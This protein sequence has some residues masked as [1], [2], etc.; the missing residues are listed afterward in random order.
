[1]STIDFSKCTDQQNNALIELGYL[2]VDSTKPFPRSLGNVVEKGSNLEKHLKEAFGE[3]YK[4]IEIIGYQNENGKGGFCGIA[5][6][7]QNGNTGI[8]FRGTE[9]LDHLFTKNQEDMIDNL[10]TGILGTS[11]QAVQAQ[12]FFKK[13]SDDSENNYLYG[14]S[15]GGELAM[16]AYVKNYQKIK[17]A[18]IYNPQPINP[19]QLSPVELL[20][21]RNKE[22]VDVIVNEGDMVSFI[23][24]VPYDY[25][26]VKNNEKNDSFFGPHMLDSVEYDNT[27]MYKE[28][29]A[30]NKKYFGQNTLAV[31]ACIITSSIQVGLKLNKTIKISD[32]MDVYEKIRK[33]HKFAEEELKNIVAKVKEGYEKLKNHIVDFNNNLKNMVTNFIESVNQFIKEHFNPGYKQSISNPHVIL[34]TYKLNDYAIRLNSVNSRIVKLDKSLDSLYLKVGWLSLYNLLKIFEADLSTGYNLKIKTCSWYLTETAKDFNNIE[35]IIV[36]NI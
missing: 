15:K 3:D 35:K 1:M 7:D 36:E 28:G 24:Q 12:K 14:H 16:Q 5:F 20:A 32:I 17:E 30:A 19:S 8:A 21:L 4:N 2:D 23:G 29:K 9:N 26:L 18:H 31:C 33:N 27:G 10:S 22:K 25:K 11:I 13:Y 34:D 6:R